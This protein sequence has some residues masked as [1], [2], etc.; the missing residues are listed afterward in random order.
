MNSALQDS[1]LH[2]VQQ[3]LQTVKTLGFLSI[4]HILTD[5]FKCAV[6]AAAEQTE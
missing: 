6:L 4:D 5:S 3:H 1:R 2:L